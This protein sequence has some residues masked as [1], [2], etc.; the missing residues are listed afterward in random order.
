MPAAPPFP[1]ARRIPVNVRSTARTDR[2]AR[3]ALDRR[4][5]FGLA[6]LF[7]MSAAGLAGC[8]PATTT[9]GKPTATKSLDYAGIKPAAEIT[10]WSNNPGKSQA[11]SQRI[12][13]AFHQAQPDIRVNLVTAGANYEEIAQK[14]QA[15]QAG[16][17]LPDLVVF[18]DVW[19][20]RY[21]MLGSIIPLD[22]L[23]KQV[24][25]E[26]GDYRDSLIA[27][28]QYNG[29]QWAIPWA[30]ST[31]LFYYNKDH[32]KAAGLPDR[33]PKTWMEFAEWAPKLQSAGTGVQH[34]FQLPALNDYA[35]WTFQN[36]L[37]GWGGG[38]SKP[39]S[40]EVSCNAPESVRA[41][42]FLQDAVYRDR[43]AGVASKDST[44][45]LAAGAA[46]ATVASTGNLVGLLK[47]AK[48]DVGAGFLPGGPASASPVCPTGGAGVGIPKNIPKENQLAAATFIKFLTSP[49]NTVAFSGATGYMPVRKSADTSGLIGRTPQVRVAIDQLAVTRTQDRARVFFPGGDQQMA[50]ACANILT[51]R[52]SV[53]A[54][55]DALHATLTG[56]YDKSV[57][58]NL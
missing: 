8:G 45:D 3:P 24:G 16:G 31:P 53:Q 35:G 44:N 11:V 39:G 7:G 57:K 14:F 6:A 18:S 15:A 5:F 48:F 29:A 34:A 21:Y 20:F 2:P 4:E 22:S 38:W 56:I 33:A 9:A 28:Y 19:W 17:K 47:A 52:R 26:T 23:I 27:D 43:W 41:L 30:R 51:E 50:N 36:N 1:N 42:Q 46:S 12:V 58:P 54:E 32:W 37:W 25:I 40:W 55:M 10:W 49:E 13:E